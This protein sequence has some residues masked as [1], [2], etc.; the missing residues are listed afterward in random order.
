S[1]LPTRI[2][3]T[4]LR[5][6]KIYL[7]LLQLHHSLRTAGNLETLGRLCGASRERFPLR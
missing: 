7:S 1:E 3:H 2:Y 5:L 4:G 6:C